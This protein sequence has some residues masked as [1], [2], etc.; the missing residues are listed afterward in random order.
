MGENQVLFKMRANPVDKQFHKVGPSYPF[1]AINL[2][3]F[4]HLMSDIKLNPTDLEWPASI[5]P[6]GAGESQVKRLLGPSLLYVGQRQ[7]LTKDAQHITQE[8]AQLLRT[9]DF[10]EA[11]RDVL[12][13]PQGAALP[14]QHN[15]K[16]GEYILGIYTQWIY[17]PILQDKQV[18]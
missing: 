18:Q 5:V 10:V 17:G 6:G 11:W 4:A 16:W 7:G 1:N 12:I 3:V 2:L 8:V 13:T 9:L 14:V 15:A